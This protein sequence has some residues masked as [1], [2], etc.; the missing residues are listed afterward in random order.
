MAEVLSRSCAK[1][2]KGWLR[3]H[4]KCGRAVSYCDSQDRL[5]VPYL[6]CFSACFAPANTKL[7]MRSGNPSSDGWFSKKNCTYKGT[8][9]FIIN[10]APYVCGGNYPRSIALSK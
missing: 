6:F 9:K 5:G 2:F 10:N 7:T 8:I 4:A 3:K 1:S